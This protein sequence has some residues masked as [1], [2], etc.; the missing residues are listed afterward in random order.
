MIKILKEISI[1]SI[2][3]MNMI[4]ISKIMRIDSIYY[5]IEYMFLFYFYFKKYISFN[6]IFYKLKIKQLN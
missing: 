5:F 6:I 1:I 3:M 4:I 2:I